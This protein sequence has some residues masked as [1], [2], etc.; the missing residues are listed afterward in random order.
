MSFTAIVASNHHEK[1]FN[2][3]APSHRCCSLTFGQLGMHAV[4]T[5]S[6]DCM[7]NGAT[8]SPLVRPCVEQASSGTTKH[9][10]GWTLEAIRLVPM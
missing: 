8:C 3:L 9:G 1:R 2:R 6:A 5:H 4:H 7:L 10:S